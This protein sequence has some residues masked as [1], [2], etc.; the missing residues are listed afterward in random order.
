MGF[1]FL[2]LFSLM[3]HHWVFELRCKM[4]EVRSRIDHLKS[5]LRLPTS[6]F[7]PLTSDFSLLD[8]ESDYKA[9]FGKNKASISN[10]ST[11]TN[12]WRSRLHQTIYESNTTAG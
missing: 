5:Y 10:M 7:L 8:I 3:F 6:D 9:Y 4:Q 11:D 1:F 2:T 12:N